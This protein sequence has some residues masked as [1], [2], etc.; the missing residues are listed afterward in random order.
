MQ[1]LAGKANKGTR[2]ES[3]LWLNLFMVRRSLVKIK[4]MRLA[5]NKSLQLALTES[6][7]ED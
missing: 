6:N 3:L 4:Q 7:N 2:A 1:L 5:V